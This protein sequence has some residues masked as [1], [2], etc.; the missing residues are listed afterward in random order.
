M[1]IIKDR[2]RIEAEELFTDIQSFIEELKLSY[3]NLNFENINIQN[4]ILDVYNKILNDDDI[5]QY[6][7]LQQGKHYPT[8]FNFK[9]KNRNQLEFWL[10]RGFGKDRF[11]EDTVLLFLY[12]YPFACQEVDEYDRYAIHHKYPMSFLVKINFLNVFLI[13]MH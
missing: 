11:D 5:V 12:V 10:E 7:R 9:Y 6:C 8:F 3:N 1:L 13:L 2:K 4:L